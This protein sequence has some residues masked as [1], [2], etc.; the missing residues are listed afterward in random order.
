MYNSKIESGEVKLDLHVTIL[1]YWFHFL[2][3]LRFIEEFGPKLPLYAWL[4]QF[5]YVY[6]F[7]ILA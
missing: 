4:D 5:D 3:Y 7:L 6:D 2:C 1:Q